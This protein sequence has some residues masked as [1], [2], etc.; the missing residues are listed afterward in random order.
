[1]LIRLDQRFLRLFLP[2]NRQGKARIFEVL[3]DDASRT[4]SHPIVEKENVDFDK[5]YSMAGD[6][7]NS[8]RGM[9]SCFTKKVEKELGILV[10]S[11]KQF[12]LDCLGYS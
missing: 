4:G 6:V 5:R 7:G 2:R 8:Y 10:I 3:A 12:A 9:V 1:V 11:H